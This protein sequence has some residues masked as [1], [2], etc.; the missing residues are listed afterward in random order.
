M[1]IDLVPPPP[2]LSL[3][4]LHGDALPSKGLLGGYFRWCLSELPGAYLLSMYPAGGMQCYV[5][6]AGRAVVGSVFHLESGW[7]SSHPTCSREGSGASHPEACAHLVCFSHSGGSGGI[8]SWPEFAFLWCLM[9]LS[10]LACLLTTWRSSLGKRSIQVFCPFFY[11]VIL[12]FLIIF[13]LGGGPTT[14]PGDLWTLSSPLIVNSLRF[15]EPLP[16]LSA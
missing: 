13:F 1:L 11:Q 9:K 12:S 15:L 10:T 5:A 16:R 8:T 2:Y 14:L 4:N 6:G 3:V 7:T